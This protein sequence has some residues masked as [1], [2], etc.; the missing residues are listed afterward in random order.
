M[1]PGHQGSECHAASEDLDQAGRKEP[2]G[3]GNYARGDFRSKPSPGCSQRKET[4]TRK[5]FLDRRVFSEPEELR[6]MNTEQIWKIQGRLGRSRRSGENRDQMRKR[7][8]LEDRS[9]R[10][11]V[12]AYTDDVGRRTPLWSNS[13]NF[14]H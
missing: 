3:D 13:K 11:M 8:R 14:P 5:E 6:E 12:N 1:K 2:G 7:I 10:T 9:V 4:E